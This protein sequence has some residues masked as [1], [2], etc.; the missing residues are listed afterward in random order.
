MLQLILRDLY[1]TIR[2]AKNANELGPAGQNIAG[3]RQIH[4]E[5]QRDTEILLPLPLSC[6]KTFPPRHLES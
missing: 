6:V 4:R 5:I 1:I 2:P 3:S